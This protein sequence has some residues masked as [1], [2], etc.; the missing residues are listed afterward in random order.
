MKRANSLVNTFFREKHS[1]DRCRFRP[2]LQREFRAVGSCEFTGNAYGLVLSVCW[3]MPF[4]PVFK[5]HLYGLM[6]L[7][8]C[9]REFI[10]RSALVHGWL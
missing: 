2:E 4:G 5:R 10:P 1:M 7:K 6:A 3:S 9:C 8:V